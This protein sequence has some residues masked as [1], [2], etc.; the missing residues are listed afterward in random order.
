MY[1]EAIHTLA[2][3]GFRSTKL[4]PF[5]EGVTQW[6]T[7]KQY[8][9]SLAYPEHV[10]IIEEVAG[11]LGEDKLIEAFTRGQDNRMG[12][13][14]QTKGPDFGPKILQRLQDAQK[15]LMSGESLAPLETQP[16]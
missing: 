11:H 13:L 5:N 14:L 1:H 7:R 16:L 6:L 8:P 2:L 10:R 12:P 15:R 9:E 4:M 3:P